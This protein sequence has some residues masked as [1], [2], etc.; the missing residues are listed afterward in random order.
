MSQELRPLRFKSFPESYCVISRLGIG[1]FGCALLAKYRM[2]MPSLLASRTGRK[3]TLM[4]PVEGKT[5]EKEYL[6]GLMAVKVMKKRFVNPLDY[7][8]VNEVRFIL[9]IPAHP[10]LMQ[11]FDMFVDSFSGKLHISMEAMNLNLYQFLDKNEQKPLSDAVVKSLLAQLLGAIR[12]IHSYGYF[13]RDIKPENILLTGSRTYYGKDVPASVVAKDAFVLKLCDYGLARH[14]ENSMCLTQYVSTRWYRA[15]EILLRLKQYSYPIDIW[16]FASVGVEILTNRPL[17]PGMNEADQL[18]QILKELGNPSIG[19]RSDE[20]MGGEWLE[21]VDLAQEMGIQLPILQPKSIYTLVDCRQPEL[22]CLLRQCLLWDPDMRPT[23]NELARMSYFA[24][25]SV[26]DEVALL[27]LGG[28]SFFEHEV[29]D[30][31][32]PL[33]SPLSLTLP[34]RKCASEEGRSPVLL[35]HAT[36]NV[37]AFYEQSYRYKNWSKSTNEVDASLNGAYGSELDISIDLDIPDE[38]LPRRAAIETPP[39]AAVLS[40]FHLDADTSMES[41]GILC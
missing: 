22:A 31:T 6:N 25:T 34:Q 1:S 15:P 8:E 38:D 7:L 36:Q 29:A 37:N 24:N 26:H 3:G 11:I 4:A 2:S 10:N 21:G 23:A 17:F 16:A 40:R 39:N 27:E 12:H 9:T 14:V 35:G 30:C 18:W 32:V 19:D 33:H 13:H 41:H 28:S 20:D 5:P